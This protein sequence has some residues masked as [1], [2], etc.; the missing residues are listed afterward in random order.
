MKRTKLR[1]FKVGALFLLMGLFFVLLTGCDTLL[2]GST[3]KN[4]NVD[5]ALEQ[6]QINF[7][8]GDTKTSVTKS[9]QLPVTVQGVSVQ[10]ISSDEDVISIVAGKATVTRQN[11]DVT[12][13]LTAKMGSKGY[14]LYK[15]FEVIVKADDDVAPEEVRHQ[16]RF[17]V[18][19][20][21]YGEVQ[22]VLD[23]NQALPPIDPYKEDHR[24]MGW[25][26]DEGFTRE[27]DKAAPITKNTDLYGKFEAGGYQVRFF[28]DGI[29]YGPVQYIKY[30]D[31]AIVPDDPVVDGKYFISWDRNSFI[32]FKNTDV[33]AV[34]TP[35]PTYVVR[36]IDHDDTVLKEQQV[37]EKTAATAPNNPTRTGYTFTGW[38]QEFN[39]VTNDIDIN[40]VYQINEYT[41]TFKVDGEEDQVLTFAYNAAVKAPQM[42]AKAGHS[43][44]WTD[45]IPATMPAENIVI[46]GSYQVNEYT[47]T[48][49]LDEGTNHADNPT[50][51]N[52]LTPTITLKP[53]SKAGYNF[54]GW[55]NQSNTKVTEITLGSTGNITLTAKFSLIVYN[56]TVTGDGVT[57]NPEVLTDLLPNSNV[58]FTFDKAGYILDTVEVDDV[59]VDVT[60]NTYTL[61]VTNNHNV[62]VTWIQLINVTFDLNEGELVGLTSPVVV[63]S[64]TKVANPGNPTKEGFNFIE[65]QLNGNKYDFDSVVT[66]PIT[67]K[68]HYEEIPPEMVNVTFNLNEGELVGLTSPVEVEKGTK[69]ANPGNPTKE[70][71]IFI[72]WQLNGET[73]DFNT[74]VTEPISL[75]AYY[76]VPIE[77]LHTVSVKY[78][79][80]LINTDIPD[81][82]INS[83]L[84]ITQTTGNSPV[85]VSFDGSGAT[86]K[87]LFNNSNSQIRLYAGG[88]LNV[89]V[90]GAVITK[91][92]W[93][94]TRNNGIKINDGAVINTQNGSEVFQDG[95]DAVTILVDGAQFRMDELVVTYRV[96]EPPEMVNVTFNLNE[97]ELLGL[98]S[99]VE[100][101]KGTKVANPGNPTKE[102]HDFVEWRLNGVK[103]N[104]DELVTE[105][106]SLDAYYTVKSYTVTYQVTGLDDEVDT[107]DF[108]APIV[109]RNNL[110]KAGYTFSWDTTNLPANM[111][112]ENL[113]VK[114][115]FTAIPLTITASGSKS[116]AL[117]LTFNQD[118]TFAADIVNKKEFINALFTH[119]VDWTV[120]DLDKITIAYDSVNFE[121]TF[122]FADNVITGNT[123]EHIDYINGNGDGIFRRHF[124]L[125]NASII[126]AAA[127]GL[128]SESVVE[129]YRL[130]LWVSFDDL[131]N[132][133]NYTE[134][135]KALVYNVADWTADKENDP[136]CKYEVVFKVNE[137][138]IGNPVEVIHNE[139]VEKPED[140][141][142]PEYIF[143][144]WEVG[145]LPYDF[146]N[147]VT[148]N[149]EITAKM[150]HQVATVTDEASLK[151]A[152]EDVEIIRIEFAND[153][154]VSLANKK[155]EVKN[156]VTIDGKGFALIQEVVTTWQSAYAFH[157]YKVTGVVIKN[158]TIKNGDAG[159]LVNG[160]EVTVTNVT[161]SNNRAGGIEVSQGGGVTTVPLLTVS[162]TFEFDYANVPPIWIDGKTTNG[163]WVV[164]DQALIE[165]IYTPNDE[166]K[167]LFFVEAT[168]PGVMTVTFDYDG[169]APAKVVYGSRVLR[170]AADPVQIGFDFVEWQKDGATYDFNQLVTAP[171]T[172]TPL[173]IADL[174]ITAS[175]STTNV[176]TLEFS[177]DVY[178][179]DGTNPIDISDIATNNV[180]KRTLLENIF[181]FEATVNFDLLDFD[182]ITIAYDNTLFK[183]SITFADGVM[184]S[185]VFQAADYGNG[186][187]DGILRFKFELVNA[188]VKTVSHDAT[189]ESVIADYRLKLYVPWDETN[190]KADYT[191][192]VSSKV[193]NKAD[194][195]VDKEND[196]TFYHSITFMANGEQY[197]AVLE[198]E[199]RKKATAPQTNPTKTEHKFIEWRLSGETSAYDFNSDVLEDIVLVAHFE[200]NQYVITWKDGNN[201][202]IKTESVAYGATPAYE[203][204][205]P[206]KTAT[207]T[208]TYTFNNSW[209]PAIVA[210]TGD[211]VYTAQFNENLRSY[212]LT[213]PESGVVAD[214]EDLNNVP[215]GTTVTL[216]INI[217]EG[218]QIVSV[219][220]D[221]EDLGVLVD[222][223]YAFDMPAKHATVVVTFEEIVLVKYTPTLDGTGVTTNPASL[224]DLEENSNLVITFT[225]DL[226]LLK[227]FTVDNISQVDNINTE[228]KTFTLKITA[229]HTIKV[230]WYPSISEVRELTKG[231]TTL[232]VGIVTEVAGNSVTIQDST[233][234]ISVFG[235]TTKPA[236]LAAGDKVKVNGKLDE[237]KGLIQIGSGGTIER[238]SAG[239]ALPETT[240]L[241]TLA[242]AANY[243]SQ[244]VSINDLEFVRKEA[245]NQNIVVKLGDNEMVLRAP[246]TS[247]AIFDLLNTIDHGVVV[248]VNNSVLNWFN[249][250]QI[251]VNNSEQ[252]TITLLSDAEKVNKVDAYLKAE[253][254]NKSYENGTDVLLPKTDPFFGVTITWTYNPEA[255][256]VADKWAQ[257][258]EV[259]ATG[260]FAIGAS[261]GSS[262]INVTV[263]VP[264]PVVEY[265]LTDARTELTGTNYASFTVTEENGTWSGSA[266]SSG[267]KI[268]TR[269][270]SG[271]QVTFTANSGYYIDAVKISVHS[272][273]AGARTV[274]IG[275]ITIASGITSSNPVVTDKITLEGELTKITLMPSGALQYEFV[276]VYVKQFAVNLA[277]EDIDQITITPTEYDVATDLT[278]PTEGTVHSS[279][280]S[281]TSSHPEIIATNGT[282]AL[283][284]DTTLVTL[285]A[286]AT[287]GLDVYEKE[288]KI[289]VI[290][291][292]SKIQAELNALDA[293]GPNITENLT[294]PGQTATSGYTI[295]WTSNN[296]AIAINGTAGTVTRAEL[297]VPVVLTATATNAGVTRY[298]EFEVTV[299]GIGTELESELAALS[300][301]PSQTISNLT[302]EATTTNN[303]VITWSSNKTAITISGTTGV[304][305]RPTDADVLVVVTAK[306]SSG[307]IE[308]IREF[309]VL[310]LKEGTVLEEYTITMIIGT[311]SGEGENYETYL[312]GPNSVSYTTVTDVADALGVW[313]GLAN[314]QAKGFGQKSGNYLTYTAPSGYYI[315]SIQIEG[316]LNSTKSKTISFGDQVILSGS[317]NTLLVGDTI[318]LTGNITSGTFSTNTGTS[319]I[320]KIVIVCKPL[321]P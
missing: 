108:G 200:I 53:A 36:F 92:E 106:I 162:G 242:N 293:I 188:N 290:G 279:V 164:Q 168:N 180:T 306:I 78:V 197:G 10:W 40:A 3:A 90:P 227:T 56:V 47:I 48:Y 122:T 297:D 84:T 149:L 160:S 103:Y 126:S 192:S 134:D 218:Q 110:V 225:K 13:Y 292:G 244:L 55:F 35:I 237:Y 204:A 85:N 289:N 247:G 314:Y 8:A 32:I 320:S 4:E 96:G 252:I 210:V 177:E 254:D 156:N 304:V 246:D 73:Y 307:S 291:I 226:G 206:T 139:S 136:V 243:M 59:A 121:L 17:F 305:T 28:V 232:F 179:T 205:T 173:F 178:F 151:A 76:I 18:D 239:N 264:D 316:N 248:S 97:G 286:K 80:D 64:G 14:Y 203:G 224:T 183:L 113:V 87:T 57:T 285:T 207:P 52:V 319:Y 298:R 109:V 310:V 117:K 312:T 70:G 228:A 146:T 98:T 38:D 54:D 15:T 132:K 186:N 39:N 71:H 268:G 175:G 20:I 81:G 276:T 300:A 277:R 245:S 216:T 102:G 138:P 185:A 49:N 147:K 41:A 75:D 16:V 124:E 257:V 311:A 22:M 230:E 91:I 133:A 259:E 313:S 233:A 7:A 152:I 271:D 157:A 144:G 167:Q 317:V 241:T 105:A 21:L 221:G 260:T 66:E 111:P 46:S 104:F 23:G 261:N 101:E 137:S 88:K 182:K 190:K 275:D 303:Y 69:V 249:G 265:T 172:L 163:G 165:V 74:L 315:Y 61:K 143:K 2:P 65:W 267:G 127:H 236:D 19:G 29:L 202:V 100:V 129:T 62:V 58:V 235:A 198:V 50:K 112:A 6:T 170:P 321:N 195:L 223:N 25:F 145:G 150:K 135:V 211:A 308:K 296:A 99:P 153:I 199:R 222:N 240:T 82:N 269:K 217:P 229:N 44:A 166:T 169:Y 278:L 128:T 158:L 45:E 201:E 302:L 272:G 1:K 253:Y 154:N 125:K 193:Y 282:M 34:L 309:E 273:A 274:K 262:V 26:L 95:V 196:P 83:Y 120:V 89:S 60:G 214:Y 283:P 256:V 24:F 12:V 72:E 295:T 234:G 119:N 266:N 208:Y 148:S 118:V 184:N 181:A 107:Y 288:F 67:L 79:G 51:Y 116:T 130:K 255:A 42:A 251:N 189:S 123:L 294:L 37:F 281:W 131:N 318:V 176:L 5:L 209:S 301:L 270:D 63:P 250:P 299:V 191:S 174:V 115:E 86:T 220:I 9:F 30:G 161:L 231:T 140:P 194:Y 213:L 212:K 219:L 68:A 94:S 171:I 142:V 258:G 77:G 27:F 238:L 93:T 287:K 159:I 263:V 215:V 141:I 31:S 33:H 187:G 155:L 284:E 280:I 11:E 43:F 114:G